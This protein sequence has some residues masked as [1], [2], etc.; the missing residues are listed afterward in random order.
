[1]FWLVL[2]AIVSSKLCPIYQCS[3]P[4]NNISNSQC[5]EKEGFTYTLGTCP[6]EYY[7][8]CPPNESDAFCQLPPTPSDINVSYI[9]E[10]CVYDRNCFKSLCTD[11]VCTGFELNS[12]CSYTAQCNV[13]TYCGNGT[14]LALQGLGGDCASDFDCMNNLGCYGLVCVRYF[15]LGAGEKLENCE[16]GLNYLCSSGACGV[17]ASGDMF[18]LGNFSSVNAVP[19][20]C[21]ND[22]DCLMNQTI[23]SEG[24]SSGC[25]CGYN[26]FGIS[27]CALAPGDSDFVSFV[28]LMMQ[29]V[30]GTQIKKCHTYSRTD[31]KC[32]NQNANYSFAVELTYRYLLVTNYSQIQGNDDS[33]GVIISVGILLLASF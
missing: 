12:T 28:S 17:G 2:I 29:W 18:C 16:N 27:Y 9:G 15:S 33:M 3:G 4:L 8:Y 31:L 24:Y 10:P 21:S 6:E 11:K 22:G 30:N 23:F 32:I 20:M 19:A 13:G 26:E 14:C 1:M 25:Q 5:I 7:S